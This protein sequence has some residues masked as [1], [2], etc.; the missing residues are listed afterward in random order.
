MT[1]IGT[2]L[3]TTA[4]AGALVGALAAQPAFAFHYGRV[5]G[6][7][8]GAGGDGGRQGGSDWGGWGWGGPYVGYGWGGCSIR[9]VPVQTAFGSRWRTIRTCF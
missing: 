9:R 8:W 1:R 5:G 7:T 4:V 3:K 6:G 2:F